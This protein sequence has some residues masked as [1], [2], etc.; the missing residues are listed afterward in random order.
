M[1]NEQSFDN[2]LI[3]N[4]YSQIEVHFRFDVKI[5]IDPIEIR[6]L[7]VPLAIDLDDGPAAITAPKPTLGPVTRRVRGSRRVRGACIRRKSHRKPE[8]S[9]FHAQCAQSS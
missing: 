7:S 5:L 2:A 6:P 4:L 3:P 9:S 1:R 8:R